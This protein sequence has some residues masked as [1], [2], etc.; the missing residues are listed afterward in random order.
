[1]AVELLNV[2]TSG[3][4]NDVLWV[5]LRDACV[6]IEVSVCLSVIVAPWEPRCTC[7]RKQSYF[8]APT[9]K[10]CRT[11]NAQ[12]DCLVGLLS[13]TGSGRTHRRETEWRQPH[14]LARSTVVDFITER[15]DR[16]RKQVEW[17]ERPLPQSSSS[18]LYRNGGDNHVITLGAIWAGSCT[19]VVT[20][21]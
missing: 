12:I 1:M 10:P 15:P 14:V 16:P 13:G 7:G 19:T 3:A 5:L 17:N 6:L 2:E 9:L 18:A 21:L 4:G 20:W 8:Y 11:L